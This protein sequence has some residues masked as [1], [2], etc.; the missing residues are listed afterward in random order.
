M[1]LLHADYNPRVTT[2]SNMHVGDIKAVSFLGGCA[3]RSLWGDDAIAGIDLC[4]S[5]SILSM[6]SVG[7][8]CTG[9]GPASTLPLRRCSSTD[10]RWSGPSPLEVCSSYFKPSQLVLLDCQCHVCPCMAAPALPEDANDLDYLGLVRC[11]S[12]AWLVQE[13]WMWILH[14]HGTARW[15]PAQV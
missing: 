13:W 15:W 8:P 10:P 3:G 1:C 9:T 11:A 14:S 2:L 4:R 12:I 6:S 5:A 7:T